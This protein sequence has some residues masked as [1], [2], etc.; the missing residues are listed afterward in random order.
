MR[1]CGFAVPLLSALSLHPLVFVPA[2]WRVA[3]LVEADDDGMQRSWKD[4]Q[5]VCRRLFYL[6]VVT[7]EFTLS[8]L[9]STEGQIN[10]R[11]IS[12]DHLRKGKITL[13]HLQ[14]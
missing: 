10:E 1:V 3:W 14:R 2:R 13:D 7:A 8:S 6:L 9:R 11:G 12:L 4:E 5:V